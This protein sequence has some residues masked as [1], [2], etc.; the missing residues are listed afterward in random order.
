LKIQIQIQNF[1]KKFQNL[2]KC[3]LK[4]F[5]ISKLKFPVLSSLGIISH[6]RFCQLWLHINAYWAFLTHFSRIKPRFTHISPSHDLKTRFY[7]C[8]PFFMSFII[9]LLN[10]CYA[11]KVV[12]PRSRNHIVLCVVYTLL[13]VNHEVAIGIRWKISNYKQM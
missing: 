3:A 4:P 11:I 6:V 8:L 10:S 7:C 12:S 9:K 5:P 13:A 1:K 2:P